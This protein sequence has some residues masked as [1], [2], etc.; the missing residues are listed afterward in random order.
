[1]SNGQSKKWSMIEVVVSVA[2]GYFVAL[3]TQ[4]LVFPFMRIPVSWEQNFQ[5]GA[6][7]T[8]VGVAR[9]Y[10]VR[11]FFNWLH[12]RGAHN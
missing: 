4:L 1:M 9:S 3:L 7:F 5:I 8:V 6:I 10:F 11:R 2:I 12:L